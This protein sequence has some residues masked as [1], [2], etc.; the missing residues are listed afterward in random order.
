MSTVDVL[1][2]EAM[3]NRMLDLSYC[4]YECLADF[5]DE[6][7]LF[8]SGDADINYHLHLVRVRMHA[9]KCL[10]D[11]ERLAPLLNELVEGVPAWKGAA[12]NR[13]GL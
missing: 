2:D 12:I 6:A 13:M 5:L 3:R 8:E 10:A 4:L 7:T 1:S 11:I 9:V